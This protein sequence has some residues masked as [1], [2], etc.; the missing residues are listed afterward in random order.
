MSRVLVTGSADGLGREAAK[1]LVRGGHEVI[2]HARDDARAQQ[3]LDGVPGATAA[4]PGDLSSITSTRALA[5]LLNAAGVFD[6]I[7]HNA[8]IGY[9][10]RARL[11][12]EDGLEHVFQINVLAP[13]LLTAL[14]NRP[15]RL[16]YLSSGLHRSGDPGLGDLQWEHRRW[17]AYQAYCDSKLF[18]AVLAAAVAR[19]WPDVL[20]SSVEPGWVR[21]KMGGR[22]APGEIGPGAETQ[23]WLATSSDPLAR[24]SGRH[25]YHRRPRETHPAVADRVIQDGLLAACYELTGEV[26]ADSSG[27]APAG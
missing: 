9:R 23:V 14:V 15:A 12:T 3:A 20:S 17:D 26:I 19:R 8:G 18:D 4:L 2:L 13:Y 10:E 11:E 1:Q 22:E 6:A 5:G 7:I 16:I 21:T 25:F 24:Q 27:T